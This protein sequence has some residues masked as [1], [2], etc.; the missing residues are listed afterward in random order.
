L[1]TQTLNQITETST[2]IANAL[3]EL[4]DSDW[5]LEA[6]IDLV[7]DQ[8]HHPWLIEINSRPRARMEMLADTNPD[9]YLAAH[10]AAAARPIERIRALITQKRDLNPA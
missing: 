8:D 2:T 9:K 6:G 5:I 3:D 1:D 10:I 4:E 7:L